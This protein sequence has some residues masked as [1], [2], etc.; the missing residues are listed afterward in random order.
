MDT[1]S[2]FL[3][4]NIF[5][6]GCCVASFINVV[7]YRVP[8]G[9]SVAKG[10]SF[11]PTCH[12]QLH[13]LDLIPIV[14]YIG[15]GGKCRY[16]KEKI[17]LRDT[18]LELFGGLLGMFCYYFFGIH[19]MGLISFVFG[20]TL[21]AI[22]IIDIDTMIIP[23]SLVVVCFIFGTLTIPFIEV[24]LLER[25]IGFFIL[26]I[27]LYLLNLLVVD[28]FGGGDI[29]LLAVC[30]FILGWKNVLMGMFIAVLMAGTFASYLMLLHKADRKSHIAFGPYICFGMFIVLLYGDYI[31]NWYLGLFGV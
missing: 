28:S 23:D 24:S 3:Y 20:M 12:H 14:S 7:I 11:C 9:I 6:I 13:A 1:M 8:L 25:I 10:R 2:L 26:S 30:G 27:P 17:S 31:L 18:L 22:A 5:V 16:C 15:L 4:V 21:L 19:W 29:K